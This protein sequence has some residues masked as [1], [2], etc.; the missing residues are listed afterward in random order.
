MIAT[1]NR[2]Q[3]TFLRLSH[4]PG[5]NLKE[6]VDEIRYSLL[7]SSALILN[8]NAYENNLQ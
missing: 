7:E 1:V 8:Y 5:Y 6:A 4:I 3:I 2:W